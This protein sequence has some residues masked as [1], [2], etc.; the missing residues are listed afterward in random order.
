ML[1]RGIKESELGEWNAAAGRANEDVAFWRDS[2]GVDVEAALDDSLFRVL[3][4][5]GMEVLA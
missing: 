4:W 3:E 1:F 5:G 2:V